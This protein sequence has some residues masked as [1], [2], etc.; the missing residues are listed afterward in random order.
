MKKYKQ[1]ITGLVIGSMLGMGGSVF[2]EDISVISVFVK[3]AIHF[4]I[5]GKKKELPKEDTVFTY[6]GKTYVPINFMAENLGAEINW[7]NK[8]KT[9]S[10]QS[11]KKEEIE[12]QERSKIEYHRLPIKRLIG[13][14]WIDITGVSI[15]KKN[16]F[17]WVY[18]EVENKGDAPIQ[19]DQMRTKM[20]AEDQTIYKQGDLVTMVNPYDHTWFDDIR[21]DDEINGF[22]KMPLPEGEEEL[23]NFTLVLKMIQNDGSQKET[24][25]RF[26]IAQ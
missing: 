22:I 23:K 16:K 21:K 14:V 7:D 10:V 20:I 1:L 15:D 17:I 13:N 11:K 18:L 12:K 4:E 8:T 24:E 2:A 19:I 6:K 9:I 26:D 25:V 3:K 5:N